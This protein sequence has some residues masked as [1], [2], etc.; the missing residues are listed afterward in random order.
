MMRYRRR[1]R[2][3]GNL[4]RRF[5]GQQRGSPYYR[6]VSSNGWTINNVSNGDVGVIVIASP[7]ENYAR[8][9][10]RMSIHLSWGLFTDGSNIDPATLTLEWCMGLASSQGQFSEA[11]KTD[12]SLGMWKRMAA[13]N[14]GVG[15][16]SHFWI[17]GG[18]NMP[19]TGTDNLPGA[20][21]LHLYF[22]CHIHSKGEASSNSDLVI[23]STISRMERRSP[24]MNLGT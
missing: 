4:N 15:S 23:A 18:F 14:P 21:D 5:R 19:A 16:T 20:D 3:I 9:F 10:R 7:V 22:G 6:V 13:M 24:F 2:S 8:F 11:M 1:R 12:H 17:P